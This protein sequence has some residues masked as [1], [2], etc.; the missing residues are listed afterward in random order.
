L[1]LFGLRRRPRSPLG[2]MRY[3]RSGASGFAG[4][5]V[6]RRGSGARPRHTPQLLA[7]RLPRRRAAKGPH[8]WSTAVVGDP[9]VRVNGPRLGGP[10]PS[11]NRFSSPPPTPVL[12]EACG[13]NRR[14]VGPFPAFWELNSLFRAVSPSAL[15]LIE[16]MSYFPML[17][18]LVNLTADPYTNRHYE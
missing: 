5:R 18:L 6:S 10:G 1:R 12:P 2:R 11:S 7:L 16:V 9:M 3:G 13:R 17:L 4:H 8:G 14:I 15:A